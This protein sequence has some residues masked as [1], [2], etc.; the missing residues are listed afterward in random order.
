MESALPAIKAIVP[1]KVTGPVM[2]AI[3]LGYPGAKIFYGPAPQ[4]DEWKKL[5]SPQDQ[6]PKVLPD[7]LFK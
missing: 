7:A 4:M 1:P 2:F 5:F 3:V 6:V